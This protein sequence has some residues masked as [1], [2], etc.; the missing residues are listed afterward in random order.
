L[1][2]R[3][4]STEVDRVSCWSQSRAESLQKG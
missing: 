3:L 2:V 1:L 4:K